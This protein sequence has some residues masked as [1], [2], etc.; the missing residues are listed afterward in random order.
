MFDAIKVSGFSRFMV[1]KYQEIKLGFKIPRSYCYNNGSKR[2]V[3]QFFA[4]WILIE[5]QGDSIPEFITRC[6]ERKRS[7]IIKKRE[8]RIN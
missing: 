6:V 3:V 7:K 2:G 1:A 5:L 4:Q 8:D